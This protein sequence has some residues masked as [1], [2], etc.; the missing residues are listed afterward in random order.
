MLCPKDQF[1]ADQVGK[2]ASVEVVALYQNLYYI[3]WIVFA[4]KEKNNWR[5]VG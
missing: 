5:K 3:K 4:V 2:N 1:I